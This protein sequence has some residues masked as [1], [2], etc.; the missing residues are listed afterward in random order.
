M[1]A[2]SDSCCPPGSHPA[3][4]NDSKR[5]LAGSVVDVDGLPCYFVA[6]KAKVKDLQGAAIVV[7]YDVHGFGPGRPKSVC[8]ALSATGVPVIM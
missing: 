8:D 7:I 1:A 6:P 4:I 3:L 5:E 2:S